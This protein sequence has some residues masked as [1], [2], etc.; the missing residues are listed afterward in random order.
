MPRTGGRYRSARTPRPG[1]VQEAWSTS[2]RK[3]PPATLESGFGGFLRE[4]RR[5]TLAMIPILAALVLLL[6][7]PARRPI[8]LGIALLAPP[9]VVG[10]VFGSGA[11]VV[12][13]ALAVA[14]WCAARGSI[15]A[16][17][18]AGIVALLAAAP[19]FAIYADR[20]WVNLALSCAGTGAAWWL[21]GILW[22][23]LAPMAAAN[24][25]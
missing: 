18:I 9:I 13:T 22:A 21:A 19:G 3:D 5:I 2:F 11:L 8:A 20:G 12:L 10:T 15:I 6:V 7:A 17:A 23:A 14:W 4:P 25:R 1:L 16:A 24:D